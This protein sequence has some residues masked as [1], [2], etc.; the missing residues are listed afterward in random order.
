M[1]NSSLYPENKTS[2]ETPSDWPV[3]EVV[4]DDENHAFVD[5]NGG[6]TQVNGKDWYTGSVFDYKSNLSKDKHAEEGSF[7]FLSYRI[8]RQG[9]VTR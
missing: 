7:L 2:D 4:E 6:D 3:D 1:F 9:L 8:V 5:Y